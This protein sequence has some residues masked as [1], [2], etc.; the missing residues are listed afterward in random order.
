VPITIFPP[1]NGLAGPGCVISGGTNILDEVTQDWH[2]QLE[3]RL[4]DALET[5]IF[6]TT[7]TATAG[8]DFTVELG[9]VSN[10]LQQ[11]GSLS[12][13]AVPENTDI[14]VVARLFDPVNVERESFSIPTKYSAQAGVHITQLDKTTSVTGGFTAADRTTANQTKAAATFSVGTAGL[15]GWAANALSQL[16][17]VPFYFLCSVDATN[18]VSGQGELAVPTL[19]RP[20]YTAGISWTFLYIPPGTG[21]YVGAVDQWQGRLLQTALRYRLHANQG[22]Y[23]DHDIRDW[24]T[25]NL[26]YLFDPPLPGFFEYGLRP[27]VQAKFFWL[28]LCLV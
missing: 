16:D 5:L 1:A 24:N 21:S 28:Q 17:Q 23:L 10:T 4:Q 12:S 6:Y 9:A 27:G 18:A 7:R 26:I 11:G 3:L 14:R 8:R 22:P 20:S 13:V 19:A 25:H 2:W 15:I